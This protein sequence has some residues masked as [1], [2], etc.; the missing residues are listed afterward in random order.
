MPVTIY[1]SNHGSDENDGR[2]RE[3]PIFSWARAKKVCTGKNEV[4]LMEGDV[5]LERIKREID[6]HGVF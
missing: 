1:I 5:T 3:T 6:N 4:H 2:T